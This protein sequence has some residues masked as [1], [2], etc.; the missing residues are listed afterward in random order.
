MKKFLI[1]VI[2][3]ASILTPGV[4]LAENGPEDHRKLWNTLQSL[5]IVTLYNHKLHCDPN[6]DV[7]GI[8]YYNSGTLIICQD[9]MKSHLVEEQ[10][11]ENDFD[12]LRHEA[13]HVLQDCSNGR[14]LDGKMGLFFQGDK[15]YQFVAG[16]SLSEEELMR[17]YRTLENAGLDYEGIKE[18]IEAHIVARDIPAQMIEQKLIQICSQ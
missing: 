12:T 14:L 11:T 8:Y 5:G 17:L 13:H 10:W 6:V 7:D 4:A 1:S 9:N 2:A 18:E 15:H 16:S 3:A